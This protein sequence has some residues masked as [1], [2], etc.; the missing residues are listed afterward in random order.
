VESTV[1]ADGARRLR[2]GQALA[3]ARRKVAR[4]I[5]DLL[6][7]LDAR[8]QCDDFEVAT[9]PITQKIQR[10]VFDTLADTQHEGAA[11]YILSR[12][13]DTIL[14]GGWERYRDEAVRETVGSILAQVASATEVDDRFARSVVRT[15]R[16]AGL[17]P[18]AIFP[19]MGAV[20]VGQQE[21]PG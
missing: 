9:Y 6:K 5:L 8:E 2:S 21:V 12:V 7:G 19:I 13:R 11:S 20:D 10:F 4:E 18:V 17:R 1:V 14:D 16:S 15:L 3:A